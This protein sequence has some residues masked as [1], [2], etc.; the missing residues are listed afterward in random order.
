M[1]T[2]FRRTVLATALA[3]S[4]GLAHAGSITAFHSVSDWTVA[5]TGTMRLEDFSLAGI[6]STGPLFDVVTGLC[7]GFGI[8]SSIGGGTISAGSYADTVQ[9]GFGFGGPE[10]APLFKLGDGVRAFGAE[11]NLGE[12][13]GGLMMRVIFGDGSVSTSILAAPLGGTF[14]GFFGV[15]A[16]EAIVSIQLAA[17]SFSA[18]QSFT[19]DNARIVETPEPATGLLILLGS[20][21]AAAYRRVRGPRSRQASDA[22]P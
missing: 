17:P 18:G 19:M 2:L 1:T 22:R 15:I 13:H 6:D 9:W 4:P 8:R 5:S 3:L 10:D 16:D 14:N 20:G 11:W 12:L 21:A 7:D